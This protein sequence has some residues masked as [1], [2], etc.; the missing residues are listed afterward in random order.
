VYSAPEVPVV[1]SLRGK[2]KQKTNAIY[3]LI[4]VSVRILTG[5]LHFEESQSVPFDSQTMHR[6]KSILIDQNRGRGC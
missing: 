6:L 5:G 3:V 4:L 1:C 2:Q